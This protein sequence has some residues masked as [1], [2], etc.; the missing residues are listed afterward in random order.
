MD[1][2]LLG[3]TPEPFTVKCGRHQVRVGSAGKAQ[4]VD[5]PCGGELVVK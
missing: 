2:S 1:G 3:Q 5:V 4:T